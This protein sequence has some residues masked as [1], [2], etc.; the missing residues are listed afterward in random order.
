MAG[1]TRSSE[2]ATQLTNGTRTP[3]LNVLDEPGL[4]PAIGDGGNAAALI[5][6]L[7]VVGVES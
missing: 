6:R 2:L 1:A 7:A 3:T 4:G 5:G